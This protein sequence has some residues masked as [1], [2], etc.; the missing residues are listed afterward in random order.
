MPTQRPRSDPGGWSPTQGH[1]LG[2]LG[3][4]CRQHRL[5]NTTQGIGK[6]SNGPGPGSRMIL[7]PECSAVPD[8]PRSSSGQRGLLRFS[9]VHV[10]RPFRTSMSYAHARHPYQTSVPGGAGE[11][12]PKVGGSWGSAEG[13]APAVL[14]PGRHEQAHKGDRNQAENDAAE[15]RFDHR[16]QSGT[17]AR[18]N[19]SM[20]GASTVGPTPDL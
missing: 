10:R 15:E 18:H 5:V 13:A 14:V 8:G 16:K 3:Q 6:D 11:A 19:S 7:C 2:A 12:R 4:A 1:H 9:L 17:R 20:C